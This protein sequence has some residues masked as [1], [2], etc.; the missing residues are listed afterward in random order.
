MLRLSLTTAVACASLWLVGCDQNTADQG[1]MPAEDREL[2]GSAEVSSDQE[3]P[4]ADNTALNK[5]DR[6][7][8]TL[9]PGDQGNSEPDR[10]MTRQIRRAITQDDE[11]STTAKNI[12]IITVDGK[13]TLRGPVKSE[14]E[15]EKIATLARNAAGGATVD[16][17][18]EVKQT[19]ETN[20]E[21]RN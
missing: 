15:R 11:L 1:G 18:L 19:T 6:D 16:N 14:A 20:T 12:K 7:D 9:T 8:L 10:Q 5:R 2:R 17:Q 3:P 21:E 4:A 13:V